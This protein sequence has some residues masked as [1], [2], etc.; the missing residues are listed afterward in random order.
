MKLPLDAFI[1]PEKITGYLLVWRAKGDKSV[2]LALAGYDPST[3][4]Q[5]LNDLRSQLLCGD[6][7]FEEMNE[8]GHT[9]SLRGKLTGPNGRSLL[10]VTIWMKEHLSGTTKFITLY[11][12]R[13][14]KN[15]L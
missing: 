12:D 15:D 13:K 3:H 10:V 4:D 8:Y 1:A 7:T 9:F 6:A 11:P 14:Q 5:L 2:F